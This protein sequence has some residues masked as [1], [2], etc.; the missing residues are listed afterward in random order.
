MQQNFTNT[1]IHL[2]KEN[3]LTQEQLAQEL[4]IS[5]QA[6][7]K[8]ENG[9]S[10]PDIELLPQLANLLHVSIDALLGYAS[11]NQAIATYDSTYNISEYYWG[12][13]PSSMCYEVMK[14]C[15]PEKKLRLI[16]IGC[17]EG[18]DAVFFARNG[19]KVSAYDISERGIEKAKMLAD[20]FS[21][22]VNFFQADIQT[23]RLDHEFDIIF[24]SGV[25]HYLTPNIRHDFITNIKAHTTVNGINM[26]N[27]FVDKPYITKHCATSEEENEKNSELWR[28]G[29]LATE[30]HDWEFYQMYETTL[31]CNSGNE[32]HKHCMDVILAERKL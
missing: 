12:L 20:R 28:A 19:Y 26:I 29:E 8:W 16:D 22:N 3:H 21:V 9:Q 17:G 27:V 18:K 5:A 32:N 30:Y 1:F 15:P 11:Q 25:L 10:Y 6:I 24:C 2:R 7:S 13:K 31:D 14:I 4:G 23:Y